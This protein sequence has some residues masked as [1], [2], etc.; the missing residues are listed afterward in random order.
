MNYNNPAERLLL[1]LKKG[2]DINDQDAKE[3]DIGAKHADDRLTCQE[4]W[5]Q[6]L[7]TEN[8]FPLLLSRLGKVIEL[9]QTTVQILQDR[10]PDKGHMWSHWYSQVTDA[11]SQQYLP[12]EWA[13]VIFQIDKHAMNYLEVASQFLELT[14]TQ[15]S[16]SE[17]EIQKIREKLEEILLEVSE[18]EIDSTVKEYVVRYI[19]KII[20]SLDECYIT[21]ALPILESVETAIGHAHIDKNYK[22]FLKETALGKKMLD[23]L[24]TAASAVTLAVGL[25]EIAH[26]MIPLL[27]Q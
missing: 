14:S 26:K 6:I 11:F 23:A 1:L 2:K 10:F 9:S 27:S 15:K 18:T 3:I 22:E 8:N 20:T 21:G 16:I 4:A 17:N 7:N 24:H 19:Q 13:A 12:G 25:P 5:N